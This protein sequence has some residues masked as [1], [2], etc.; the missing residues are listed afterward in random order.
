VAVAVDIREDAAVEA[1]KLLELVHKT[2]V[3]PVGLAG[4]FVDYAGAD[5]T[6]VSL[7]S[8]DKAKIAARWA[9]TVGTGMMVLR[10]QAKDHACRE[11]L[12]SCFWSN[13]IQICGSVEHAESDL[14]FVSIVVKK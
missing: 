1:C 11:Q 10:M 12:T 4:Q 13:R 9:Y 3:I 5:L 8:A 2:P 14:E 7:F 6:V